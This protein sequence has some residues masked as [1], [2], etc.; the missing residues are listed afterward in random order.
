F[1]RRP[2]TST[3]CPTARRS[4][5]HVG[6]TSAATWASTTCWCRRCVPA[7]WLRLERE[8]ERVL[9]NGDH[10]AVRQL[11]LDHRLAIDERPVGAAQVADPERAGAD[12]DPAV[13]P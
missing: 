2:R 7:R 12:I 5:G 9:A 11:L 3:A 1:W 10:V 8:A 6:T 13:M 4:A